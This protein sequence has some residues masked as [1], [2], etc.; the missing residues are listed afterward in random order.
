MKI[1]MDKNFLVPEDGVSTMTILPI[2]KLPRLA[3]DKA[4]ATL[5]IEDNKWPYV[6]TEKHL[7]DVLQAVLV[8]SDS[9]MWS[10]HGPMLGAATQLCCPLLLISAL[11]P[12]A[13]M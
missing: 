11:V 2:K 9:C 12:F 13:V 10:A 3:P 4:L 8:T 5:A 1:R 7:D 6:A